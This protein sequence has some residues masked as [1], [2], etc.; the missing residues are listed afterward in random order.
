MKQ[1]S[2][3]ETPAPGPQSDSHHA[4]CRQETPPGVC[5]GPGQERQP[6]ACGEGTG[7]QRRDSGHVRTRA[8]T[9]GHTRTGARSPLAARAGTGAGQYLSGTHAAAVSPDDPSQ[10][11][12]CPVCLSAHRT[13]R[14]SPSHSLHAREA[15]AISGRPQ[16]RPQ[17][18]R[19]RTHSLE[20]HSGPVRQTQPPHKQLTGPPM[21]HTAPSSST[22]DP[23]ATHSPHTSSSRDSR[24][25]PPHR[26][27][28]GELG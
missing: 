15:E 11:H 25:P 12:T 13:C 7:P 20:S 3:P 10:G 5:G 24:N 1:E 8:H 22:Q 21:T 9:G 6:W 2:G 4:A 28:A 18:P 19:S 23:N 26:S 14:Q 16:L 27:T 17:R